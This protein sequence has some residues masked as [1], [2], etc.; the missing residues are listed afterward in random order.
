MW[1]KLMLQRYNRKLSRDESKE[2]TIQQVLDRVK[3]EAW[4]S[5]SE[6]LKHWKEFVLC[7][8]EIYRLI[9]VENTKERLE[10][11]RNDCVHIYRYIEPF[12]DDPSETKATFCCPDEQD[13]GL[14]IN[15]IVD[16]L[17]TINNRFLDQ[18]GAFSWTKE[19]QSDA[20]EV[21]VVAPIMNSD[22]CSTQNLVDVDKA[23]VTEII[24]SHCV[25]A[26]E[27]GSKKKIAFDMDA[28]EMDITDKYVLGKG[29]VRAMLK[30]FEF[31]GATKVENIFD[32]LTSLPNSLLEPEFLKTATAYQSG[33]DREQAL[34]V[35]EETILLLGRLN[36]TPEPDRPLF[37]FM[38]MTLKFDKVDYGLFNINDTGKE[39]QLRHLQCLWEYLTK[40]AIYADPKKQKVPPNTLFRYM[41]EI[42]EK[43]AEE[44]DA[45]MKKL[46]MSDFEELVF[47]W[48][49]VMKSVGTEMRNLA[50]PWEVW[51]R[52]RYD[53]DKVLEKMPEITLAHCGSVYEYLAKVFFPLRL[54]TAEIEEE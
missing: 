46:S 7:W 18:A 27:F 38:K 48:F 23:T 44:L 33:L 17:I 47:D 20:Q 21:N 12:S 54:G 24:R 2:L 42:D 9:N 22:K 8:N 15:T 1:C 52:V 53:N 40:Q 13:D 51:I 45:F 39:I 4:G 31:S 43:L 29:E 25:R 19:S 14:I 49:E 11:L 16:H 41:E 35:L 26:L 6:Y 32:R 34:D 28:C 37:D 5:D 50:D 10:E 36:L 3:E 30:M